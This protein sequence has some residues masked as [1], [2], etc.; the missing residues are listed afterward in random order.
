[1]TTAMRIAAFAVLLIGCT[2]GQTSR[3]LVGGPIGAALGD[4]AELPLCEADAAYSVTVGGAGRAMGETYCD[5]V[6]RRTRCWNGQPEYSPPWYDR[7]VRGQ[8]R[9]FCAKFGEPPVPVEHKP[10]GGG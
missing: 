8:E 9:P 4:S 3:M 10:L 5:G 1:M 6:F 2:T 7:T